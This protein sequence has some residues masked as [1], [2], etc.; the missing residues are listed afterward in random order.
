VL[1]TSINNQPVT[2]QQQYINLVEQIGSGQQVE[3][4]NYDVTT[5]EANIGPFTKKFHA[6]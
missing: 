5:E 1:I 6:P 3:V 2:S 4:T